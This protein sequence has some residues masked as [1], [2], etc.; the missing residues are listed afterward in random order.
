LPAR[1]R[2]GVSGY[3][4]VFVLVGVAIAA[5]ALA[6]GAMTPYASSLQGAGVTISSA[7]I[8]Q[9]TYVALETLTVY[10]SGSVASSALTVTTTPSPS[11]ASYC[12]TLVDPS[13]KAILYSSCP[14]GSTNPGS[15]AIA[16]QMPPGK[17]LL[18]ELTI[19]G[20]F[21][22]GSAPFVTVTTSAGSQATLSVQVVPA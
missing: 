7:S 1:V 6:F 8:R 20:S 11:A 3:I 18:I 21:T 17:G 10:N 16:W 5:T 12:Y 9:G 13:T 22:I 19:T 2:R 14:S 15:V 4:E